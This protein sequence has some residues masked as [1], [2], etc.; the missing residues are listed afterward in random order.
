[1]L[2]VL[3]ITGPIYVAIALGFLLTRA[4]VFSKSEMRV[5]GKFVIQLAL[6]ALVFR[7]LA[8]R[9]IAEVLVPAY[10]LA[11]AAGSL[12]VFAGAYLV[13]RR[14]HLGETAS[15]FRAVGM[16]CSNS[17]FVGYPIVYLTLG[18]VAGVGL[19]LNMVVENLVMIP[20]LLAL[21]EH[22]R[23]ADGPWYR[24][25]LDAVKRL[26]TNPLILSLLAGLAVSVSG[27]VLPAPFLR[28]VD[29]FAGASA[30]LSLFVIGG[31][32]VGLPLKGLGR[33]VAPIAFGKL[34]LHPLAVAGWLVVLLF[35]GLSRP[36]D[37]LLTAAVLS[38]A[39]PM[40]SIYPT[41]A[42]AYGEDEIAA[43][44]L[45]VTTLASFGTLSLLLWAVKHHLLPG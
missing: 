35:A 33:R 38:A 45:L 36:S 18:P 30:G 44:A 13:S 3:A 1:M 43:P 19:A 42:Q 25:A 28:T 8:T 9:P 40:F 24:A 10:L 11:Y 27:L 22:G 16:T 26:A 29:L 32:L 17:G 12:T 14:L 23:A 4:D 20:L 34:V 21:A 39:M 37:T 6:P 2:D 41:L 7:T 31:L 5:F 15:A